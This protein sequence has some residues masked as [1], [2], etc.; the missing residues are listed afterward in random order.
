MIY[1]LEILPYPDVEGTTCAWGVNNSGH[2]AGSTVQSTPQN[3]NG[4]ITATIWPISSPF[5]YKWFNDFG[6]FMKINDAGDAID[7]NGG[8]ATNG[9][10]LINLKERINGSVG[11]YDLN[12][13]FVV[14]DMGAG[15]SDDWGELSK[16][17][18][19]DW[20]SQDLT[21]IE[22]LNGYDSL[23]PAGI[24]SN[25]DVVGSMND[26]AFIYSAGQVRDLGAGL[27]KDINDNGIAVGILGGAPAWINCN[28]P[29]PVPN[30]IPLS[31]NTNGMATAINNNGMVVGGLDNGA[32]V[33]D[34]QTAPYPA[35]ALNAMIPAGSGWTLWGAFDVNDNG[36]ITGGAFSTENKYLMGAYALTPPSHPWPEKW[37]IPK[38]EPWLWGQIPWI[39]NPETW[40][41]LPAEMQ[42]A[43]AASGIVGLAN[44][45]TDSAA[46]REIRK[47]AL[48]VANQALEKLRQ[49]GGLVPA[50]ERIASAIQQRFTGRRR[51]GTS[52]AS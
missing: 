30:P 45:M 18:M 15:W 49:R 28:D 51:R 8:L 38:Y 19:Y 29:N 20:V 12:S 27:L 11:G 43:L 50:S 47:I 3:P 23:S 16:G 14:G 25:N 36:Q 17:F 26:S 1:N 42:E 32:F 6:E 39:R 9:G 7:I 21:L 4:Q 40:D 24:N 48:Q 52:R 44:L 2:A 34:I 37:K 22:P 41:R 31:P 13:Q 46:Q 10:T 35:Q 33:F 5:T